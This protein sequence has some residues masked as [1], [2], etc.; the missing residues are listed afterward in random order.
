MANEFIFLVTAILDLIFVLYMMKFGKVGPMVAVVVNI[1]LIST[2][3]GKLAS[4][5][6]WETNIGN[7]FLCRG[8]CRGHAFNGIL[9]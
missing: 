7:I 8:I 1:I 2:F 6:G 3:G 4:I 9:R 5:F